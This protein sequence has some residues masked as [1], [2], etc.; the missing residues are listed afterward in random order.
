MEVTASKL[1]K[2]KFYFYKKH[3]IYINDIDDLYTLTFNAR[4]QY[5]SFDKF[6]KDLGEYG[7]QEYT[8]VRYSVVTETSFDKYKTMRVNSERFTLDTEFFTRDNIFMET[9]AEEL[10]NLY[11]K[12]SYSEKECIKKW[13]YFDEIFNR[14]L[15]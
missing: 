14:K 6:Y 7:K 3:L 11:E 13:R 12:M 1:K 15:F 9:T 2:G 10:F 8:A 5:T 4:V